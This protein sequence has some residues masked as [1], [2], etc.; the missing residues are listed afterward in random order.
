HGRTRIAGHVLW[1][2]YVH[3]RLGPVYPAF[4]AGQTLLHVTHRFEVFIQFLPIPVPDFLFE[5]PGLAPHHIHDALPLLQA[6][7]LQLALLRCDLQEA[8]R[9]DLTRTVHGRDAD[10]TSGVGDL[11]ERNT[12]EP[13]LE[14]DLF[15]DELI[16]R[17]RVLE[18]GAAD[19][20][21]PRQERKVARMPSG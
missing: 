3:L 12:G 7:H 13:G 1:R 14:A 2:R 16:Q 20:G 8:L 9:E 17:N 5:A 6:P 19:A 15:R 21:G 18:R 10:S 11:A 4:G